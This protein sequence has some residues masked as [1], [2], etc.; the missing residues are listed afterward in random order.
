MV[1]DWRK[2]TGNP[3]GLDLYR[4]A[5]GDTIQVGDVQYIWTMGATDGQI[6]IYHEYYAA[7]SPASLQL[8]E[9]W[10]QATAFQP[11]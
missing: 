10:G 7:R 3:Y 11:V 8:M 5:Q 9:S 4:D 2:L 6:N 1:I